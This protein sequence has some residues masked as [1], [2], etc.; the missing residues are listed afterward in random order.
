M[1]EDTGKS[2]HIGGATGRIHGA[3][4]S[5]VDY[6]RAGIP[7]VEI[8]TKPVVGAGDRAPQVARAYVSALRDLLKALGVSD[9]RMEQG[10]LR[11]DANLSLRPKA[12]E[13]QDQN[14]VPLGTRTET[15][16]VNSLR[17]V[18]RAIRY[19]I[20]R[21]A[22]V[23]N[24]GA[25]IVQ[26]TRHWQ[27]DAGVTTSGRVK[28]DADDYRYFPEPDLLPVAPT[29]ERVEELRATLPEPPA[30]RRRRLQSDWGYSDLEMRDVMNAGAVE[31]I[32]ESVD[33]GATPAGARKWWMGELA[34]R[35]SV[36]GRDLGDF[37][38]T[39]AHVAQ[40]DGLVASGRLNDSMARQVLE[41]VLSGEGSPETVAD[42]N[43]LR[44]VDDEGALSATVD[45]VIEANPV[46]ADKVR[47][48]KVAAAGAL[49]GQVMKEM[50]GQADAAKVREL[51]LTKLGGF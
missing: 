13:G 24:S 16:N 35:A 27:E 45:A 10:S 15:K 38:V 36:E 11:C 47:D 19:E 49:I 42:A 33:A 50:K 25:S 28:S 44:L 1:E 40:L 6:N 43:G 14:D 48:G 18:E 8:V 20:T 26:E 51:I 34:R 2:L 29:R 22:A 7:L 46:V 37:G 21:H 32:E 17:S 9:V 12:S 23:L 3:D 5:L 41:G 39:P 31:L 30:E 4:H